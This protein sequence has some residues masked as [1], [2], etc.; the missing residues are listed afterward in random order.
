MHRRQAVDAVLDLVGQIVVGGGHVG[1][2]GV[3][4]RR[5][6]D[7]PQHRSH[8]GNL[9]EGAVAVPFVLQPDDVRVPGEDDHVV[10]R[11]VLLAEEEL[12]VDDVAP[13]TGEG[14][15]LFEGEVLVAEE[16]QLPFEEGPV[17][18]L[19]GLVVQRL[20]QIGAAHLGTDGRARPG[21][22]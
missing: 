9:A 3:A 15:V 6:L 17:E 13:A 1:V 2:E 20:A 19:E 18:L 4:E 8:R 12:V 14:G 5:H 16:Q 7:G 11:V 21:A 10:H 22:G